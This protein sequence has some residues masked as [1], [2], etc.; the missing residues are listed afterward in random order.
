MSSTGRSRVVPRAW[1]LLLIVAAGQT[2]GRAATEPELA[3]Q[4]DEYL[5]AVSRAT[6]F[7]GSVLVAVDGELVVRQGYGQASREL[8]VLNAPGTRYRIG[9][10]TKTFTAL[11]ILQLCDRDLLSLNDPVST[12]LPD[13]PKG[14]EITV[15]MLL[16]H[17]S[18]LPPR[19][20]D[21]WHEKRR[22]SLTE[23]IAQFEKRP[24]LSKPGLEEHYSNPGYALLTRIIEL[25]SGQSYDDYVM[26]H[27]L[28]PA[29]MTGS[30]TD[31]AD[32]I[33]PDRA[34]GY[35]IGVDREGFAA[36]ANAETLIASSL[37]GQASMISTIDDLYRY[38]AFLRS[39]ESA[40]G[41]CSRRL[42]DMKPP[43]EFTLGSWWIEKDKPLGDLVYFSGVSSGFESV[44]YRYPA[45]VIIVL[46]NHQ[47]A[48]VYAVAEGISSILAGTEYH[49]PKTRT[50]TPIDAALLA[51]IVGEYEIEPGET[52][53]ILSVEGRLFVESHGDPPEELFSG[54]E[55]ELFSELHDLEIR[56]VTD[57]E[58]SIV[59]ATWIYWGDEVAARKMN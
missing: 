44:I 6:A 17:T 43:S 45:A 38:D 27:V 46:A 34:Q 18:G 24:L 53:Q 7:S 48:G 49:Q 50:V 58:D 42:L 23:V 26:E 51:R 5:V 14:G 10:L 31:H 37:L 25:A 40:N 36:M 35:V 57:A 28:K 29:G 22:L 19:W 9:S 2:A 4:I 39:V 52:F 11:G 20:R 21:D 55:G 59:G 12:F 30:G 56:P 8:G 16:N 15:E 41:K 54:G 1:S 13:F 33:V 3:A 32:R 47:S